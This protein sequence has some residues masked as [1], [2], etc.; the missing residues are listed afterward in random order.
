MRLRDVLGIIPINEYIDALYRQVEGNGARRLVTIADAK[1]CGKWLG[2]YNR[3]F[4]NREYFETA[5]RNAAREL[6][7]QGLR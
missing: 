2:V 7:R 5:F 6:A 4:M 1:T 3:V